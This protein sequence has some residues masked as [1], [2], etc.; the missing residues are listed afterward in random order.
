MNTRGEKKATPHIPNTFFHSKHGYNS[1]R[2]QVH[3][4]RR[5]TPEHRL[6]SVVG[7]QWTHTTKTGPHK[8][9]EK[10]LSRLLTRRHQRVTPK[11]LDALIAQAMRLKTLDVVNSK[12]LPAP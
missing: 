9:R 4:Y 7:V 10:S 6:T 11:P 8:A 5:I 12:V 2:T 1:A 3:S